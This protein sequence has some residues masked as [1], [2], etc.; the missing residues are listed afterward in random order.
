MLDQTKPEALL[1]SLLGRAEA[2]GIRHGF[3]TRN[4]GVS[5]G[6]YGSLNVGFGSTDE[7]ESVTENRRRVAIAMGVAPDALVTVFQVHS[8]DVVRV[9]APFAHESRPR[10][11]AMVTD[12]PGLALGVQTAD[13]G[14]VL[15]ADPQA[16]VIGAAHAGWKGALS[17]ILEN[18][19]A[20]M[21]E[22][23][24]QRANI[25]AALGPAIGR[26]SYEVG[27]EFVER[28]KAADAANAR[29]FRPSG[30]DG[31][32]LFDLCGYI[33][34]RLAAAGVTA[35]HVA[36]CT[37]AEEDAFYSYRRATHRG[38]ADYGRQISAI[39]LEDR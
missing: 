7:R 4:G 31:H 2:A 18:T 16:R 35:D 34:V 19:V 28:F 11:D 29:F 15:F 27:S 1:S 32:A 30:R 26:D 22:L 37:Y 14:P 3:F 36:R 25:L 9:T 12:R 24:A 17:G 33:L 6:I 8:P 13:C 23:G 39:V 38:E 21:E 20:A 5:Q 10:A